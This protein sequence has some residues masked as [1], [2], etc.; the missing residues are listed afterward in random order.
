MFTG[1]LAVYEDRRDAHNT[2]VNADFESVVAH[3]YAMTE[4]SLRA[5]RDDRP[6]G[7]PA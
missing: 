3:L 4:A 2:V 5:G 7:D 1:A 6:G